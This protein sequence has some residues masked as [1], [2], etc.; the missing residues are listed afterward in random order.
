MDTDSVFLPRNGPLEVV[1]SFDTTGSMCRWLDEL[2]GRIQDLIQRLQADIPGIKM[3]VFAHGDY[4]DAHIYVTKWTDLSNNIV[5]LCEFVKN[6]EQTGGGD[7]PEC[8]ELVL[9]QVR[10]ELSW[11]PGSRR[12]LVLIGDDNP[13]EPGEILNKDKIDWR[14]EVKALAQEGVTIYG[15]QCGR[16]TYADKFYQAISLATGGRHLRLEDLGSLFDTL[17]AVCYREGQDTAMLAN[18]EKEVRARRVGGALAADIDAI[19]ASLRDDN[20]DSSAPL[21]VKSIYT[22]P[23]SV[24]PGFTL[25][26]FVNPVTTAPLSVNPATKLSVKRSTA[27]TRQRSISAKAKASLN[28][29]K[30]SNLPLLKRENVPENNFSLRSLSWSSWKLAMVSDDHF[31]KDNM[32]KWEKRV[33]RPGY[34]LQMLSSSK[35]SSVKASKRLALFEVAVQGGSAH[36]KRYVVLSAFSSLCLNTN[37]WERRLLGAARSQ[38]D[39][40]LKTGCRIYV[41]FWLVTKQSVLE[42]PL[43]CVRRYDYAWKRVRKGRSQ[44]RNVVKGC[45]IISNSG[46]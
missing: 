7:S 37:N 15:V 23:L 10:T 16:N 22:L 46:F 33:G 29:F 36:K 19:F 32:D 13:H 38:V 21:T 24:N 9:R 25:P 6:A 41:R 12:V 17:M 14:M 30:A 18:Y 42:S 40:A 11:T 5:E 26:L 3:A 39:Y 1:F 20:V 2:R 27:T 28:K 34:R 4:C 8:Y 31:P 45:T 44:P 35:S 43:K